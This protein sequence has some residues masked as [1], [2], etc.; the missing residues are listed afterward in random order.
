MN[1]IVEIKLNGQN[2]NARLDMGAIAE[3][4]YHFKRLDD[5]MKVPE[6]FDRVFK[7]D[8]S[9]INEMIVQSILSCHPQLNRD[10]IFA[11]MKLKEM[12]NIV[13]YAVEL[14]KVSLPENDSKK[15]KSFGGKVEDWDYNY[16]EYLWVSVLKRNAD[17]FKK[18]IP[19]KI[20]AQMDAHKK[21]NN[22]DST[23]KK[24]SIVSTTEFM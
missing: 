14:L 10:L 9:V 24:E 13:D 17:S 19:K 16:L 15:S 1:D 20:F 8:V 12:N 23:K 6:L 4:Q 18:T 7:A 22:F 3:V 5:Y 21:Y 2:Y 11:N